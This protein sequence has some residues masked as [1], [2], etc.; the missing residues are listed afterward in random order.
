MYEIKSDKNVV[1]CLLSVFIVS[2]PIEECKWRKEDTLGILTKWWNYNI[3]SV[4]E[5]CYTLDKEKGV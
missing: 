1:L 2:H 3:I 5:L 4:K